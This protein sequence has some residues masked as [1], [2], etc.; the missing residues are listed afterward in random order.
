MAR[1]ALDAFGSDKG[2]RPEVE[3]ALWAA[4]DGFDVTLVGDRAR[5]EPLV[6]EVAR[7]EPDLAGIELRIHHAPDVITMDDS[8]ALAVRGKPEAS[9]PVAF[10]LVRD[11][12]ADAVVSAGNSGA[13]LACGLLRLG[14]IKGVDRPAIAGALPTMTGRSTMLDLGANVECRPLHLLQFAVLGATFAAHARHDLPRPRVALLSNGEEP[15]KGTELTRAAHE[16]LT[17]AGGGSDFEFCGYVEGHELFRGEVDVIVTDGFSG[18]VALK[19]AEGTAAFVGHLLK[20]AIAAGQLRRLGGLLLR[21]AFDELRAL[22]DP[23]SY[24]GAP[25]LGVRGL[26]VVCHGRSDARAITNAIRT[27]AGLVDAGLGAALTAAITRH[28]PLFERAKAAATA[29]PTVGHAVG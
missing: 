26:A 6:R 1:I 27:T 9:M 18:N 25:L 8:P 17:A 23:A 11:G 14:R 15:G 3:G 13:M 5:L 19:T 4:R 7:A 22:V 16:L 12:E 21:P 10:G 28:R 29:G 20:H 2:P 24:G